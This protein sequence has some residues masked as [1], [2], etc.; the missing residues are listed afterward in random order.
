MQQRARS[1]AT[2]KTY[3]L[4]L[5]LQEAIG[6]GREEEKTKTLLFAYDLMNQGMFVIREKKGTTILFLKLIV[7]FIIS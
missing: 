5:G 6:G 2:Q 4:I 7:T 3:K 1:T